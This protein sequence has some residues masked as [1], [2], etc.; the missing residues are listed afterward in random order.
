MS[1][2]QIADSH[3]Y[4][5][6]FLGLT[7]SSEGKI[8]A[9]SE[10]L[11]IRF[12]IPIEKA[13]RIAQNAPIIVKKNIS[14]SKAERYQQLFL[15]LGGQVRIEETDADRDPQ[16]TGSLRGI[17]GLETTAVGSA[18]TVTKSHESGQSEQPG[19]GDDIIAKAYD[20]EIAGAY[21]DSFT[22]SSA[23]PSASPEGSSFR[24]P[25]C[26]Q[27]QPRGTECVKCGVIFEK[28]ERMVQ[29]KDE[30][31]I[32]TNQ[33]SDEAEPTPG[34][35]EVSIEPAGFWVRLAAAVADSV[36]VNLVLAVLVV[37]L[38]FLLGGG[39]NPMKVVSAGPLISVFSLFL[40]LT[41]HIY[42]LGKRG[43]TPGKGFLGL[44]VIRQD[45]TGMSYGDA[46]IRT[47]SYVVS[48]IPLMLGFL[49]VAFDRNKQGWH[50][51]IAKTQAIKAEEVSSWRKWVILVPAVLIP[52]AGVVGAV[53][54]PVYMGYSSRAN[55]ARAVS[56]MQRMKSRL[57]EHYYRYNR[58]PLSGEFRSFLRSGLGRI[59]TDP[60]NKGLP[61]RYRS[62][63][64]E[65]VLWSIGPDRVDNAAM[66][67][68]DPLRIRGFQQEGDIIV[69]S[70][71]GPDTSSEMTE[72]TP[73]SL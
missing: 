36:V 15:K 7:E 70:D 22:P 44:Q 11:S 60:F 14:R 13:I 66:V 68:Y 32:I 25:Q 24:C 21:D 30:T 51:K 53:G 65:F 50:D 4:R 57:E 67:P 19:A 63:G 46:A 34:T 71:E 16:A 69:Y 40:A 52:I 8:Q 6:I 26:G 45:G 5:V 49:W 72:M 48:W 39:L 23:V 58:Y 73:F 28:Y 55:V 10:K 33:A 54:I 38:L 64:S 17:E 27:E 47:F 56:E 42:F 37:G 2:D 59:P 31:E 29:A 20:D 12:G 3:H 9:F 62:D 35:F 18:D 41:Y 1:Q 61:Y 43:Y